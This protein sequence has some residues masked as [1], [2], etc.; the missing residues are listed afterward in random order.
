MHPFKHTRY[1]KTF[2]AI[3]L[4]GLLGLPF[5]HDHRTLTEADHPSHH[6]S[7]RHIHIGETTTAFPQGHTHQHSADSAQQGSEYQYLTILASASA[8][9]HWLTWGHQHT[10][11]DLSKAS[12]IAEIA[13][14]AN[15]PV[16][17]SPFADSLS[18][19]ASSFLTLVH[20]G[21]APPFT[22]PSHLSIVK[23]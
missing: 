12:A 23:S 17:G 6:Q 11:R 3:L 1:V 20:A 16:R 8:G 4:A 18:P 10:S 5:I 9:Q 22:H 15:T 19:F 7:T 2:I 13:W 14:H 21:R